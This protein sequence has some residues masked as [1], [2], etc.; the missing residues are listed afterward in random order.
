MLNLS[1][2]VQKF[3]DEFTK[4]SFTILQNILICFRLSIV[5]D[6]WNYVIFLYNDLM[7]LCTQ[8]YTCL[9]SIV[10][11]FIIVHLIGLISI[12]YHGVYNQCTV[13]SPQCIA[14]DVFFCVVRKLPPPHTSNTHPDPQ[15]PP[16]HLQCSW[17]IWWLGP[18]CDFTCACL[19]GWNAILKTYTLS[20]ISF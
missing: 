15:P 9:P 16:L 19:F 6:I 3:H 8:R 12:L 4:R 13:Y 11:P 5:Y 20:Y 1:N 17:C 2:S 7:V 10:M 18:I 14:F